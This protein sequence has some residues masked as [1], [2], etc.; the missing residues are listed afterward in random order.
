MVIIALCLQR[1]AAG[2]GIQLTLG[3]GSEVQDA[4]HLTQKMRIAK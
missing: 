1:D 2:C 4:Q 3:T